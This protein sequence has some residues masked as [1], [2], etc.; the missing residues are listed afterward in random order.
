MAAHTFH[1][2]QIARIAAIGGDE[3]RAA[4][5]IRGQLDGAL[6][7]AAANRSGDEGQAAQDETLKCIGSA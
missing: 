1:H 5:P 3:Y 4:S 2:F 7:F 6:A